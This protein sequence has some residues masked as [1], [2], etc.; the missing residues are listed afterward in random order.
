LQVNGDKNDFYGEPGRNPGGQGPQQL[1]NLWATYKFNHGVLKNFGIG[2]GGNYGGN[3]KVI[4]NSVTGV[5]L[6]P[7]YTLLN[8][9]LF[10][11]ARKFRVSFALNNITNEVYYTGYWSVN[12]Q[13]P[14]NFAASVAYKF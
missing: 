14:R 13:K 9:S 7:S 2:L 10:Y 11:N 3:Y 6:L 8:S 5:F 12:P 1:A 4:D